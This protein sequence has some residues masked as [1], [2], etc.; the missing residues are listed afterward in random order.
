MTLC[1]RAGCRGL[2]TEISTSATFFF[3]GLLSEDLCTRRPASGRMAI[4]ALDT[5]S[6][7]AIWTA[8]EVKAAH[9]GLMVRYDALCMLENIS[10]KC[11]WPTVGMTYP[12]VKHTRDRVFG[13]PLQEV[14]ETSRNA[15]QPM[16]DQQRCMPRDHRVVFRDFLLAVVVVAW[17]GVEGCSPRFQDGW[18]GCTRDTLAVLLT[19]LENGALGVYVSGGEIAMIVTEFGGVPWGFV[20]RDCELT[21]FWGLA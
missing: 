17:S 13:S 16:K 20:Q 10:G 6:C 12:K 19:R 5:N 7:T 4:S 14:D 18:D 8:R 1:L 3:C 2:K 9:T 15:P 21:R 11:L